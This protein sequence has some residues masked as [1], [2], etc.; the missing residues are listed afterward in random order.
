VLQRVHYINTS[1]EYLWRITCLV[2]SGS[3]LSDR[4]RLGNLD[5]AFQPAP[6]IASKAQFVKQLSEQSRQEELSG[7]HFKTV[8]EF[9]Q[10][11]ERKV[12]LALKGG[13]QAISLHE[14]RPPQDDWIYN[15]PHHI[16][17]G[18]RPISKDKAIWV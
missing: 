13:S 4:Q 12:L 17:F 9:R 18:K 14:L 1:P 5:L 15:Q 11:P 6:K 7:R 8:K 10:W 2:V 16:V 3:Y